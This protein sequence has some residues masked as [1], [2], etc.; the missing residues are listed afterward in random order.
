MLNA[1]SVS[2]FSLLIVISEYV[3]IYWHFVM[4]G[5]LREVIK[6][7]GVVV[8]PALKFFHYSCTFYLFSENL[9]P[10]NCLR[11]VVFK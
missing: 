3:F 10:I 1:D 11:F 9:M 8:Y 5:C 4:C 6:M 2:F 7:G